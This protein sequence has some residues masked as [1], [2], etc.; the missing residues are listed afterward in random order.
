MKFSVLL[1]VYEKEKAEYL[2][3]AIQSIISQTR[4]PNQIVIVKDGE[5]T[6]ELEKVIAYYLRTI[7]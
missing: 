6:E 7:S 2:K 4:I 5:L 1:S 3:E